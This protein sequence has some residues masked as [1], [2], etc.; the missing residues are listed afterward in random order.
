MLRE[1]ADALDRRTP[2]RPQDVLRIATWR[3]DGSTLADPSLL[4]AATRIASSR[5]GPERRASWRWL[6]RRS[7][8]SGS[9]AASR[10]G[11]CGSSRGSRTA[12]APS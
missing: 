5:N 7:P 2:H 12:A 8:R 9:I 4:A 10:S 1:L 11:R 3:L 6:S